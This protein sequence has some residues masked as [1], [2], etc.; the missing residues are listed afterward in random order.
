MNCNVLS[1]IYVLCCANCPSIYIGETNNFRLRTNLHRDHINKNS[2]LDVSKHIF[3]CTSNFPINKDK[4]KIMPIFKMNNDD[5][6]YRKSMER[7]FIRKY[8][9]DLN[10]YR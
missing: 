1:C 5:V 7:N 2:G 9:P 3:E 8:E 10:C 4:F 6:S